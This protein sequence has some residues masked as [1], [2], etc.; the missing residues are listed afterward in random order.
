MCNNFVMYVGPKLVWLGSN[1]VIRQ[2]KLI[3][4]YLWVMRLGHGTEADRAE[5]SCESSV[6]SK[7]ENSNVCVAQYELH[8]ELY[9]TEQ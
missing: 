4:S 7:S 3:A 6:N 1:T 9:I 8:V 2:V 5:L